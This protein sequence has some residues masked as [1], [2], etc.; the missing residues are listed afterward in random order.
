LASGSFRFI[1]M[2]QYYW[3]VIIDNAPLKSTSG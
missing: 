3:T 1:L 2:K